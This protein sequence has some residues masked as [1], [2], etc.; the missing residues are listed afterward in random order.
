MKKKIIW[1]ICHY[2][3]PT[4]YGY[5]GRPFFLAEEFIRMGYEVT[6]FASTSNY[7]LF[8]KP[9]V[10]RIFA[11]EDINGVKVIWVKGINYTDSKG[12]KRV[13]SWFLFSFLLL[14]FRYKRLTRPDI[15]IVSSLSIIPV[16][17]GWLLKKRHPE[18]LFIFEIRDIWPKTLIDIGGYSKYNPLVLV[19]GW[20][21]KFGYNVADYIVATMPRADLHIKNTIRKNFKFTCI[22]Q[23]IDLDTLSRNVDLSSEEISTYFPASGF[24]VGYAGALGT[25][26]S[27]DTLINAAHIINKKSVQDIH[28]VLLGDGNAKEKLMK[29]AEGLPN[30]H[31]MPRIPKNKVQ[32]FLKQCNILHDSVKPVPLYDYGLSRNKWMDYMISGKPMVVSY[33]GFVSLINEAECGTVV[34]AGDPQLL[35]VAILKYYKM[36]KDYVF[37]N[38]TFDILAKQYQKIFES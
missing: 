32:S 16:I 37:R 4:K 6:I 9:Y 33:S 21:E 35:A 14:F 29:L 34:T 15:I 7:Q 24:V 22:P 38:R 17:N 5:G 3:S 25:S 26:N 18:S 31:F 20:I 2:A 13:V 30:V 28:F 12:L 8:T 1:V 27:L 10:K 19:L 23:G 11:S 36:D